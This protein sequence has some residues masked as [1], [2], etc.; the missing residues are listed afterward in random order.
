MAKDKD[1]LEKMVALL[2]AQGEILKEIAEHLKHPLIQMTVPDAQEAVKAVKAAVRQG[3]PTPDEDDV[4]KAAVE[5][6]AF[7]DK[8]K[9][10]GKGKAQVI[11]LLA[12]YGVQRLKDLLPKQ[13]AKFIAECHAAI[14]SGVSTPANAKLEDRDI[15]LDDLKAAGKKFLEA[16]G[17]GPFLALLKSFEIARLKDLPTDRY[18]AL[19]EAFDNA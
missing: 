19:K 1:V 10:E 18:A 13:R 5:Y 8:Q 12:R 14:E 15:T 16:N 3:E 4:R 17:E 9:G 11:D 6:A 7:F 2:E